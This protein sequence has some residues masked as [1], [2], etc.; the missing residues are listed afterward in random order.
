M[1]TSPDGMYHYA[2]GYISKSPNGDISYG[3]MAM[4]TTAPVL[5]APGGCSLQT[6]NA[7]VSRNFPDRTIAV[8]SI[9]V[10]AAP[11]DT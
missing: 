4:V 7:E 1:V 9:N 11:K 5:A 8:T 10:L 3:I 6:V 2:I